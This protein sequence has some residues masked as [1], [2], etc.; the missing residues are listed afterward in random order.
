MSADRK[1]LQA[2]A[3]SVMAGSMV[4]YMLPKPPIRCLKRTPSGKNRNKVKAGR[5]QRHNSK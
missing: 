1:A 2:I 3:L 4:D 5:K